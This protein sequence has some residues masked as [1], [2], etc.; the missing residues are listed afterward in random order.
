MVPVCSTSVLAANKCI[1]KFKKQLLYTH[2]PQICVRLTVRSYICSSFSFYL[3]FLIW[4]AFIYC[5]VYLL[6]LFRALP[7]SSFKLPWDE[8]VCMLH[9]TELS[10]PFLTDAGDCYLLPAFIRRCPKKCHLLIPLWHRAEDG[11]VWMRCTK[12]FYEELW[13]TWSVVTSLPVHNMG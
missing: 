13:S 10:R 12:L 8:E 5:K 7:Y 11:S 9:D 3:F 2:K 4:Y 1:W 6:Y